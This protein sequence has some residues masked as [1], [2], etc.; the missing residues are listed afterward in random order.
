MNEKQTTIAPSA[1]LWASAFVIL[2]LILVTAGRGNG[3]A[4]Y[5]EMVGTAGDYTI[6]TTNGG[7]KEI[8]LVLDE[9]SEE[10]LA[11]KILNQKE[12]ELYQKL[13]LSQTFSD[14]KR[15]SGRK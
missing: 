4:A 12:I 1:A 8:V 7:S 14:A 6:M 11:Y 5:A 2:A 9:R 13:D 10:L 3:N 15:W